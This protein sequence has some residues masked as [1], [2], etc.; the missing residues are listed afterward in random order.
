MGA[1]ARGVSHW[2]AAWR[3]DSIER[4]GMAVPRGD[5]RVRRDGPFDSVPGILG[6]SDYQGYVIP[7]C[8]PS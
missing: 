2:A 3:T 1:T 8:P 5:A 7:A 4:L 6:K